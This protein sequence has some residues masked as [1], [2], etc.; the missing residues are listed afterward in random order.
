MTIGY[1][2][3]QIKASDGGIY[4]Y[5]IYLLKM[6]LKSDEITRIYIFY[7]KNQEA[8]FARY[9]N[10]KKVV[11]VLYDRKGKFYN[12]LKKA[13]E[14]FLT[15]YYMKNRTVELS[16]RIYKLLNP[17][18]RF[19][20]RFKLDVLHVPRQH[21]P[22]YGLN[23]PVIV[24][25]HD[26]QQFHFPEFFTPLERIYK[27]IRYYVTMC[28]AS[29]VIVSYNHVKDDLVRYFSKV[30]TEVSVCPVPLDE[31]WASGLVIPDKETL[32]E[33]YKIPENF[34][35]T[36]AA[37]WEHK[38][39]VAVLEAISLLHKDG[40]DVFWVSTGKKTKF[41]ETL[42]QKIN[43]L[44][45]NNHVLFAGL[46]PDED[47]VGLYKMAKL[48]VI[49]TLYEAGSGPLFE[50]MRYQ[51]PVICSNITSLPETINNN[52]FVFDPRNFRQIADLIKTAL[53]DNS[54]IDR[55]L[56]NSRSRVIHYQNIN[57][58]TAFLNAYKRAITN[59]K[60]TLETDK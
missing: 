15:R 23:Y 4:Q 52:E 9:L 49:P 38:N 57:Y 17:D 34:A 44:N 55:N 16:N 24:S 1:Y 54:F 18:R 50:A 46:V 42:Q 22:A 60:A 51:I 11:A 3:S 58:E 30:N 40:I 39:H 41:Y 10:N 2:I 7:S 6:L 31:D 25:M 48:V 32:K 20:N 37:T 21:S 27:S 45:L 29:H 26:V 8:D 12:T 5:S 56:S 47:L 53:T 59:F 19:L 35:I 14:Y 33:K 43:E 36:P 13:S 28:E